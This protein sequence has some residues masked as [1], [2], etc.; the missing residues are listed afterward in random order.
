MVFIEGTVVNVVLPVLQREL[1]ASGSDVQWVVVSYALLLASLLL[2]GGSLGDRY[3]RRLIFGVGVAIFGLASVV[4]GLVTTVDQLIVARAV[5]GI[6][7]ALLVPGSL[8]LISASFDEDQRGK[9]IGIWSAFSAIAAGIGPLLGG[10]LVEH[11]SWRWAFL[12]SAPIALVI[13]VVLFWN[14]P[15]SRDESSQNPLDWPGAVLAA[16][17]L[18][19]IVFG[20]IESAN[21]GLADP[22]VLGSLAAGVVLLGGFILA[23]R[24]SQAPMMPLDLF[25]SSTF[26]GANLVTLLLYTA[27][28]GATFYLPF[29]L[30]QVRGYGATAAGSALLPFVLLI[31]L[32][33]R[34]SGGLV[35]VTGPKLPLVVGSTVTALGIMLL[36]VPG[37][38]GSY[39]TT[40]FPGI[41]VLGLGMG[42]AVAPL[43]TAV[44]GAVDQDV[45]GLASGINNTASRTAG[46]LAVTVMGVIMLGAFDAGLN[47][48][49]EDVPLSTAETEALDEE[50]VNLAAAT[51]PPGLEPE[52]T[53]LVEAAIDRAFVSA[54]RIVAIVCGILA[55]ASAVVAAMMIEGTLV[56][57]SW[58]GERDDATRPARTPA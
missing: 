14:V 18:G 34:W 50:A 33:S 31:F 1:N 19:G 35:A 17:G 36:A 10:W 46:A 23:E 53:T 7:G 32:L 51:I 22:A 3:G 2:I 28:T 54:F 40:F 4:C 39:W 29:N 8:A 43:T 37:T 11:V 26:S 5:Q 25:R 57:T 12:M 42:I 52:T 38:G 9:A 13:L 6:G 47:D 55:L 30:I 16:V 48:R 58:R 21:R 24:R 49:L 20:L 44:M 56:P 27:M 41:T 15:E 45:A